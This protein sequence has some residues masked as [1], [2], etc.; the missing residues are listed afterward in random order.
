MLS[1]ATFALVLIAPTRAF[2]V[3][4]VD[5]SAD[6]ARQVVVAQGTPTLYQG[7]CA[8]LLIP[9]TQTIYV[10]WTHQHGGACGFLKRSDDGGKTWS[11]EL[12]VPAN[13]STVRNCPALYRLKDPAGRERLFVY[14]GEGPD[15]NIYA[16]DSED[17]GHTW[18]PMKSIGIPGVMPFTTIVPIDGGRALLGM[19]N[20]RRPGEKVE[21]RSNVICQS[22]SADGGF[23]WSPWRIVFDQHGLTPCEPALVRS[24]DGR[25]LFC[26]IRDNAKRVALGMVSDD[27]GRTWSVPKPLPV[28]LYGDRHMVALAPDGRLVISFRDTGAHSPTRNHFVAWVGRYAD[29]VNG[30]PGEYRVKLLTS[31]HGGDDGYSGLEIL[32]DET[33]VATTYIK[34]RPGP[35][36]N[37]VVSTRFNLHETDAAALPAR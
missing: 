10:V 14:A 20:I 28:P 13:W 3:P 11:A 25:Q 2:P 37:S 27:E 29:L 35:E 36:L 5:L 17:L 8:T 18:S 1:L 12:P 16:S 15:G 22:L 33:V 31:Y 32:P 23:T 26:L 24:P 9:G 6:A 4:T 7:H 30:T 21:K 34:Y 19:S